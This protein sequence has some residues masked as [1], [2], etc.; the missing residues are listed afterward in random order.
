MFLFELCCQFLGNA[1]AEEQEILQ[2]VINTVQ[3]VA[4]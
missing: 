2:E 3:E 1:D 4:K